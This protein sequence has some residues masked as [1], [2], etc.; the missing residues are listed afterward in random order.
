METRAKIRN[1][2]RKY[3]SSRRTYSVGWG[4]VRN[5]KFLRKIRNSNSIYEAPNRNYTYAAACAGK[6]ENQCEKRPPAQRRSKFAK[7]TYKKIIN[8][9]KKWRYGNCSFNV[10]FE[11]GKR[12]ANKTR[13]REKKLIAITVVAKNFFPHRAV[14]TKPTMLIYIFAHWK[15]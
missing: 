2:I 10:A 7:N 14:D 9:E 11:S 12:N 8:I 4:S 1:R 6:C 15:I 3:Y 13:G 5:N